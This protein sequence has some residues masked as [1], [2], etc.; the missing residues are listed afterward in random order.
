MYKGEF[1][2]PA[3]GNYK[4]FV[5]KPGE[6]DVKLDF[7]VAEPTVEFGETAMNEP[8]LREI[9]Q[10]SGG[11]FFREEDIDKLPQAISL[12]TDRVGWPVEVELWST[13]FFFLLV[14]SVVTAEWILRKSAQ[15][16]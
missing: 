3:P 14:L 7:A 4:F 10:I 8:L 13:K 1:I 9:A 6:P 5:D 11:G 12:K 16:K 2:A 15:L